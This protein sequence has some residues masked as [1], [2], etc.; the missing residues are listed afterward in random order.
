MHGT[1]YARECGFGQFF[2]SKVASGVAEFTGRLAHPR[3]GLWSALA[4]G[5]VCGAIAI[6]AQDLGDGSAHL[7]W[8]IM[9]DSARGQGIGR[10]LLTEAIRFCDRHDFAEIS[11]WTFR[12]L[13]AARRLYE[14][15]GFRLARECPGTQWG[16]AVMEQ[17]FVRHKGAG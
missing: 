8:F 17:R 11:L 3:N 9:D 4:A 15:A 5:R 1:W 10:R 6:D 12:G 16:A 13:D 14:D 2:E 7:R